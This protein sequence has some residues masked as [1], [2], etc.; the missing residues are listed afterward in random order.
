MKESHVQKET[1]NFRELTEIQS[2]VYILCY[3]EQRTLFVL[4]CLLPCRL[5]LQYLGSAYAPVCNAHIHEP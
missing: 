2:S 4:H 5:H 1:I 3:V